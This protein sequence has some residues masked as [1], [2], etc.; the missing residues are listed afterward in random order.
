MSR[1]D[2]LHGL[3]MFAHMI[4][5]PCIQWVSQGVKDSWIL[6]LGREPRNICSQKLVLLPV[7]ISLVCEPQYFYW[8]IHVNFKHP[9]KF[10]PL[11][12]PSVCDCMCQRPSTCTYI[13]GAISWVFLCLYLQ[14]PHT[15]WLLCWSS[16]NLSNINNLFLQS[17]MTAVC[18]ILFVHTVHK[19]IHLYVFIHLGI[20]GSCLCVQC[21]S[22]NGVDSSIAALWSLS[23]SWSIDWRDNCYIET[24]YT[25]V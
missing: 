18:G 22:L 15:T 16:L 19:H 12:L 24:N 1:V 10:H 9:P 4:C 23:T 5:M 14:W 2:V 7:L 21:L 13:R 11:K 25:Y 3:F 17:L 6:W 20:S 8:M